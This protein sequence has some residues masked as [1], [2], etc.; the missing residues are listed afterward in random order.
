MR[1]SLAEKRRLNRMFLKSLLHGRAAAMRGWI[2]WPK[3]S[4]L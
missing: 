3:D 4:I 2:Q 1:E